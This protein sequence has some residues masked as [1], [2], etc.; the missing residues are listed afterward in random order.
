MVPCILIYLGKKW[1]PD[2]SH[3]GSNFPIYYIKVTA[4]KTAQLFLSSRIARY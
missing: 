4:Q 2:M 3:Q 1:E